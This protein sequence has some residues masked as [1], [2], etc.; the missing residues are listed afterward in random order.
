MSTN[1]G[2][3]ARI[4]REMRERYQLESDHDSMHDARREDG[5]LVEIKACRDQLEG[6]QTGRFQ[7]YEGPHRALVRVGGLYCFAVYREDGRGVS[8]LDATLR[9]ATSLPRL[10]WT[11]TGGHDHGERK[12][13]LRPGEVL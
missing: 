5:T 3:G 2:I 7:V 8:V 10:S 1:S 12:A 13:Y 4:E 11:D 9:D 6:G